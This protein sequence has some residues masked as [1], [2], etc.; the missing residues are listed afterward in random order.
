VVTDSRGQPALA[1]SQEIDMPARPTSATSPL[2]AEDVARRATAARTAQAIHSAPVRISSTLS[3]GHSFRPSE[4]VP[5][6]EAATLPGT[7]VICEEHDEYAVVTRVTTRLDATPE[8]LES[9][10]LA[11]DVDPMSARYVAEDQSDEAHRTG[12][13]ALWKP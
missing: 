11:A 10:L 2:T 8:V 9:L 7:V 4:P 6:I 3:C 12:T 13:C 5:A 1:R